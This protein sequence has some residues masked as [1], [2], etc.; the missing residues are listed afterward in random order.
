MTITRSHA[1]VLGFMLAATR[2]CAL[3]ASGETRYQLSAL[4][5]PEHRLPKGCRLA[6]EMP[7]AVKVNP[8]VGNSGPRL[9]SLRAILEGPP[10]SGGELLRRDE[11]ITR[12][13]EN[14]VEG[15]A[16]RYLAEGAGWVQVSAVR[17]DDPKWTIAAALIRLEGEAPRIILGPI[18]VHVARSTQMNSAKRTDLVRAC[19]ESVRKYISALTL[20]R[21]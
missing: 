18:A 13:I 2:L 1:T 12:S 11:T 7:G 8:W 10:P 5:V 17:F 19:F 4:T 6:P 15:Y 16:A 20:P 14:M 9:A 3:G 21:G